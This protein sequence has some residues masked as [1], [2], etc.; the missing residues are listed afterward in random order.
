MSDPLS[1]RIL[2]STRV[3][4]GGFLKVDEVRVKLPNDKVAYRD[5]VR[6]P[7]AVAVIAIRADNQVL[8]VRQYRTALERVVLEIPAGKLEAEEDCEGC[9]RREL[10]EE[11]GY[12]A[13]RMRY[14]APIA[15]AAGYS[16]EII[17][18]FLATDLEQGQTQLDEDEFVTCEWWPLQD[19]IAEVLDGK[20]E[21]SKTVIAALL[22]DVIA[23]RL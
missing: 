12:V 3:Y 15:I 17:H 13:R 16:D 5:V 1:E 9:A 22:C 20:I 18:L 10:A 21:D 11:T 4:D 6:H 19:L 2:G 8:L 14:L 23:H 7:G